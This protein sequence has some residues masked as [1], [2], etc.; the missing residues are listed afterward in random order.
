MLT[1]YRGYRTEGW[2]WSWVRNRTTP[3]KTWGR[4]WDGWPWCRGGGCSGPEWWEGIWQ[5]IA[6]PTQGE[7]SE[8]FRSWT[9]ECSERGGPAHWFF[10]FPIVISRFPF[11]TSLGWRGYLIHEIIQQQQHQRYVRFYVIPVI[12]VGRLY[13]QPTQ[14]ESVSMHCS[15]KPYSF[16]LLCTSLPPFICP[17]LCPLVW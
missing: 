16:N 6:L 3:P 10:L 7:C 17:V 9:Q 4:S 15:P 14:K 2:G 13:W 8:T 5:V 1:K 11:Y 12:S